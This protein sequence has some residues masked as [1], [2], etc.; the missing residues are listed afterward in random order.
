MNPHFET[1]SWSMI[2]CAADPGRADSIQALEALCRRYWAPLVFYAR[3]S[4]IREQDAEDVTQ[5]FFEHLLAKNLPG[6]TEP[7]LGRF[8]SFLMVSFRN[9]MHVTRRNAT[10]MRRGGSDTP[11]L[12]LQDE[13]H[14]LGERLAGERDT[15]EE[16][17]DRKWAHTVVKLAMDELQR[18]Q[19]ALGKA[20]R[21]E[22]IRPLLLD[23]AQRGDVVEKL[24][25]QMGICD[26][27]L[28]TMLSRMR[29]RFRELVYAEVA[30]CVDDPKSVEAEIL[31]LL[32][33]LR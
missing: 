27:A 21:F 2:F 12:S 30:R 11:H 14:D 22:L 28:R 5:S 3:R 18:E 6:R 25:Q 7:A 9:F 23:P 13:A 29:A 1:T 8:R 4:G 32:K 10:R 33:L 31:Y 19:E 16:E 15:A 26:A 20:A 24:R 17:F